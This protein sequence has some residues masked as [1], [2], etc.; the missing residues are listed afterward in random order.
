MRDA[1]TYYYRSLETH[2]ALA[3]HLHIYI[4]TFPYTQHTLFYYI[5]PCEMPCDVSYILFVR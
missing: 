5:I 3:I 2:T 1:N 4:Y